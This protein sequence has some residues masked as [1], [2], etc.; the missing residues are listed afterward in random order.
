ML[1]SYGVGPTQ[2]YQDPSP[3]LEGNS[4]L[5]SRWILAIRLS[6]ESRLFSVVSAAL[7]SSAY[8]ASMAS[9]AA[10]GQIANSF[11][12]IFLAR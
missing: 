2:A 10:S 9:L 12:M 5:A 3:G 11:D 6:E 7:L 8:V 4:F 1:V